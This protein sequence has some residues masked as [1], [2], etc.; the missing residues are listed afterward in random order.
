MQS[1]SV[2][3]PMNEK[4][5]N[6]LRNKRHLGDNTIIGLLLVIFLFLTFTTDTFFKYENL[7]SIAYGVSIQFFAVIGFTFLIIMGEIDLS[8]GSMYGLSGTLV[9]FCMTVWKWSLLPSMIAVLFVCSLFGYLVGYLITKFKLNSMMVTLGTLSLVAGINAV[10]FNSFPAVI[11]NQEYRSLAKFKIA[12]IHW[13]IIAMFVIVIVLGFL[14]KYSTAIK[15]VYYIGNNPETAHLYGIK[16]DAIKKFAFTL[17][18]LTAALG[19]IIA[20]SRITHSDVLTGNGLEFVLIT[21]LVVGGA[22]LAGGRGG[23]VKSLLGMLFI[24]ILSTGMTTFRI[25][26]FAQQVM[27][28]VVLIV[29]VYID[30]NINAKRLKG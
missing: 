29:T 30:S 15:K 22:S 9:G 13:T 2:I 14:F 25:E 8:V 12:G 26:P 6:K 27:L 21:G 3:D 23:I 4:T 18:A 5:N 24:A 17:S 7:Y 16:S 20:T 11:Y 19:G 1:E 10:V 28:G